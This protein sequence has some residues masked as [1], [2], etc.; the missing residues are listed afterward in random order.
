MFNFPDKMFQCW[1]VL[2]QKLKT[3]NKVQTIKSF[4]SFQ[5]SVTEEELE[6]Q[7][8]EED[9][10]EEDRETEVV[11]EEEQVVMEIQ[12]VLLAPFQPWLG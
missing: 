10:E 2:S 5:V 9:K 4:V 6:E 7:E 8:E 11:M 1:P 12:W 3:S